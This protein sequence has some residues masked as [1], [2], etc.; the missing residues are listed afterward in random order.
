M[1]TVWEDRNPARAG[2]A[3]REVEA[4]AAPAERAAVV[5]S[6]VTSTVF[7][8]RSAFRLPGGLAFTLFDD[9]MISMTYARN[10]ARGDGLV[11]NAGGEAV[12]GYTNFL[13]TLWMA[14]LHA[15]PVP[16]RLLSLAVMVSGAALLAVTVVVTGRTARAAGLGSTAGAIAAWVV[17]LS[18][19]LVF[20]TL[21][22][23][24]VGLLAWLLATAVLLLVR[25]AGR[26]PA[27]RELALLA[28]VLVAG[29]LTR[30]DFVLFAGVVT[31]FAVWWAPSDVRRRV[32]TWTGGA[33][34]GTLVAHTVFRL[35]YYG[36]VTPNTYTLKLGG[37]GLDDRLDRGLTV[38]SD[39]L[40]IELLVPLLVVALGF[41]V[42]PRRPT[43]LELLAGALVGVAF[44]YV[45]W[46]GGD[47]WE[48][49]TIPDRYVAP[50]IPA[51]ALLV[52]SAVGRIAAAGRGALLPVLLVVGTGAV[53]LV[54]AAAHPSG[55]DARQ[56]AS[57]K[58]LR[59]GVLAALVCL[60][61]LAVVL[62][63][64]AGRRL[65]PLIAAVTV[66]ST[67]VMP[68][69]WWI[70]ID[71]P[72]ID[73]DEHYA[74]LGVALSEL[75]SPA[76]TI[77]VV[78]AGSLVYFSDRPAV[79]LL[80]KSD[81]HVAHTAPQDVPFVPGHVKYDYEWS[82]GRLRPD[83][84]VAVYGDAAAARAALDD[85][86]YEQLRG[87][88]YVRSDATTVDRTGLARHLERHPA[89]IVPASNR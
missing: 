37:I 20:W 54:V 74:R 58:Y 26:V 72:Y 28:A 65:A 76:A 70:R 85:T 62:R 40:G 53:A 57:G 87:N 77:A 51:L 56:L 16:D 13:W 38:V 83:L 41:V 31:V 39:L 10:L 36:A 3:G 81:V 43:Q 45:V 48:W 66:A 75:T 5:A 1:R 82:I 67:L 27:R 80:G 89:A 73:G 69:Y 84:V 61:A 55:P 30:T 15:T 4:R 6:V 12:E 8:A 68:A 7:L 59:V 14:L 44:A 49:M 9:A 35:L 47:A 23:M 52:A 29:I 78:S 42:A 18:P 25:I 46:T 21:R 19:P 64:V 34:V 88:V 86:G 33:I 11:W 22:G 17:A 24:E 50:V 60:V 32:L 71:A 63:F 79:D 2:G